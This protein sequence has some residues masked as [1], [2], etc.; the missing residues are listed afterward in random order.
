MLDNFDKNLNTELTEDDLEQVVGG[1]GYNGKKGKTSI[2]CP[3]CH[4]NTKRFVL[5]MDGWH[6]PDCNKLAKKKQNTKRK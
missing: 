1:K 2:A 4:Q 3:H 6:C 5:L